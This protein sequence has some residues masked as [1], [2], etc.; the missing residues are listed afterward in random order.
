MFE[1]FRR[2]SKGS[3]PGRKKTGPIERYLTDRCFWVSCECDSAGQPTQN[4][5]TLLVKSVAARSAQL[6]H[7]APKIQVAMHQ[8]NAAY[9]GN[10][11]VRIITPH[12]DPCLDFTQEDEDD[13]READFTAV[14][15]ADP[16]SIGHIASVLH[17]LVKAIESSDLVVLVSSEQARAHCAV[18]AGVY[19]MLGRGHSAKT[20]WENKLFNK[21]QDQTE[22]ATFKSPKDNQITVLSC[23]QSIEAQVIQEGGFPIGSAPYNSWMKMNRGSVSGLQKAHG[24]L[25]NCGKITSAPA[26]TFLREAEGQIKTK[27]LEAEQHAEMALPHTSGK[28]PKQSSKSGNWVSGRMPEPAPV[29]AS[30]T[31]SQGYPSEVSNDFEFRPKREGNAL[32]QARHLAKNRTHVGA[33]LSQSSLDTME[34]EADNGVGAIVLPKSQKRIPPQSSRSG[35]WVQGPMPEVDRWGNEIGS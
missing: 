28:I 27:D 16:P 1:A 15:F 7:M 9:K 11:A 10:T 5:V 26:S 4:E 35:N 2:P 32:S 34:E 3:A 12:I 29:Y 31:S 14:T 33:V 18:I 20:A 24:M 13:E 19:L 23:L 21:D 25:R 8:G 30:G 22:W 6:Q 17:L